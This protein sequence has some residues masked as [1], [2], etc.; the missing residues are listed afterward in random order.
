MSIEY[1]IL[2]LLSWR[3]STGYELKKIIEDSSFM[4]WSGNNNQIYKALLNLERNE[5]VACEVIQQIGSP[6]K[7]LYSITAEGLR[8]LANWLVSSPEAPEIKKSFLVQFAWS[9]MLSDQE[10]SDLLDRYE[11]EIKLQLIMHKQKEKRQTGQSAPARSA[12]ERLIWELISENI[13]S[14]YKNELD[15]IRQV[16]MKLLANEGE[17]GEKQMKFQIMDSGHGRYMEILAAAKPLSTENDA[18]ELISLCL[19][20]NTTAL[21]IHSAALSEDFFRLKTRVAGNMIQKFINYGIK[22]AILVPREAL[23]QERF[24]ELALEI[25]KGHHIRL[26]DHQE[27]AATWLIQQ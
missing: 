4:H 19:E 18:I 17:M 11:H 5:L 8:E 27:D 1:A 10:I 25:N 16:R 2:G 9:D 23:R 15:W 6:S 3:P 24:K 14:T 13:I 26:T 21:L 7:K 12:R 20:H 22:A